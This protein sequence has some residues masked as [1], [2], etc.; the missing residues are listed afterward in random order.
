LETII[1]TGDSLFGS[2]ATTLNFL[3]PDGADDGNIVFH[4]ELADGRS[5]IAIAAVPEA[6]AWLLLGLVTAG[7]FGMSAMRAHW[8]RT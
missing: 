1:K 3:S 8:T 7:A 6:R 5:G 2:N 4:Y